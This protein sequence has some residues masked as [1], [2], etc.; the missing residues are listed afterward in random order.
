MATLIHKNTHKSIRKAS[1]KA[2]PKIIICHMCLKTINLNFRYAK[3]CMK[4]KG[5]YN[6]TKIKLRMKPCYKFASIKLGYWRFKPGEIRKFVSSKIFDIVYEKVFTSTLSMAFH[7]FSDFLELIQCIF[8]IQTQDFRNINILILTLN[9]FIINT[10][11]IS[12]MC[13][14]FLYR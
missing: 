7:F 13:I 12:N 5:K 10:G 6:Y 11:N 8:R 3:L 2:I 4:N 9:Y 1:K 14:Y